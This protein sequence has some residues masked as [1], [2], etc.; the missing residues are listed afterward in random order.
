MLQ[1]V[2]QSRQRVTGW[3]GICL[4]AIT[5]VYFL[6]FAQFAFL[7]RLAALG[8]A[9]V[10]FKAAMTA[11]A[12]GGVLFSLLTPR[13]QMF[14]SPAT[15]LRVGLG[16]SS[17][18]AFLTLL[19]LTPGSC[20]A[21]AFFIGAGLGLLT[22]TLV[23]HLRHWIGS[24]NALLKVGLGTGVGY[25]LCNVPLLFV[26]SPTQQAT[27]A[28]L[29]CIVGIFLSV[30][31][32]A[33][34]EDFRLT[35]SR[36]AL[37]RSNL[38]FFALLASFAALI[39]LDSAAFFI[40][41]NTPVLK[42]GTWAGTAHLWINAFLHLFAAL[43][44]AWLLT[45]R[46]LSFVLP[47][48]FLALCCACL[49]LS[50]TADIP[51]ASV[52]YPIGVSFY[53][54]ALIA[55]P[56][57]LSGATTNAQRGRQAGWLYAIAGWIGS[58]MGIGMAQ[59]LGHVPVAFVVAAGAAVLLPTPMGT[60]L[61][62]RR[63][64]VLPALL[65]ATAYPV[66]RVLN[67]YQSPAPLSQIECGRQ[68]YISEGCINCHSQYVRPNSQDVL[69]WGPVKS[70]EEIHKQRPPLIGNRRQGPDLSQVGIRRSPLWLKM[71]FY[72]P[73]EV[74]GASIMPAY[75]FLFR[76]QRGEDLVA[77]LES[78]RGSG[79]QQHIDSEAYWR[80]RSEALTA[81]NA[82]DGERLFKRYCQT[83]HDAGGATRWQGQFKRLPPDLTVGPF[84]HLQPSMSAGQT[85]A[86]L[87]Q[88][89]KFGIPG[90]DMPGHEY[91][92]D[93]DIASLSLW[94]SQK[95]ANPSQSHSSPLP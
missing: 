13:L 94:V 59:N 3:Q 87:A 74:S 37:T 16:I 95:I 23:T 46:G 68:V 92:N 63:E 69:I 24:R 36:G 56:S 81:A 55:Y 78:L 17:A 27:F 28:G 86:R 29:L 20:L 85:I 11:M 83:C 1:P 72:D 71:H 2:P 9:G 70:I 25:F 21:V 57:L 49:L 91:L 38:P 64:F 30:N 15:R 80:L 40:I 34:A 67:A 75:G 35:T 93:H 41:Q 65:L 43:A 4:V 52:L 6:I 10:S 79:E 39:W 26:A 77:F 54:V 73:P 60:A 18:S 31:E 62:R 12:I 88:I 66:S 58:A 14:P 48:A 50:N 7:N 22:V 8:V 53:S 19:P 33:V 45:R 61:L 47:A 42:A 51:F 90:T 32:P 84:L 76:D 82:Q 5:Y 44:S 89:A